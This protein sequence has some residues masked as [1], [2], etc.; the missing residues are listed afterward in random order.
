[1]IGY[2]TYCDVNIEKTKFGKS[3]LVI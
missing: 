1:M 3:H 2:F